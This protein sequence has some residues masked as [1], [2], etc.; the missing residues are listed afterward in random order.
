MNDEGAIIPQQYKVHRYRDTR[1]VA[2]A[3]EGTIRRFTDARPGDQLQPGQPAPST[4][5]LPNP[6]YLDLHSALADVMH[7]SGAAEDLGNM[8][9]MAK[10]TVLFRS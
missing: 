3:A 8:F 7:V 5:D 10:D 2:V 1:I 4:N 9:E 6:K